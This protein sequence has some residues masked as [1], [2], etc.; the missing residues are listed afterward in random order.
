M[1]TF[2]NNYIAFCSFL[3]GQNPAYT[4]SFQPSS[5]SK[6]ALYANCLLIPVLMW[7]INTFM[8]V[9]HTL[10]GGTFMAIVASIITAFLIFLV[11]RA[12][13]MAPS[14]KFIVW[15]RMSLGFAI[16]LLGSLALDEVIFKKDIDNQMLKYREAIVEDARK[17]VENAYQLRIAELQ[18]EVNKKAK[19]WENTLQAASME[20]DGTGGSGQKQVG[21]ITNLKLSVANRH[22]QDYRMESSKLDSMKSNFETEKRNA[23]LSAQKNFSGE[24]LLLR[25]RALFDLVTDNLIMLLV[26]AI[27]TF[28]LFC[29]EFI[30]VLVKLFSTE[31]IDEKIEKERERLLMLKTQKITSRGEYLYRPEYEH[32]MV[33]QALEMVNRNNSIFD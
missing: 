27:F 11:E 33:K 29:L 9:S 32:P 5:K 14:N 13:I 18:I 19:V 22:E 17:N 20:A 21:A 26:Y 16:A 7:L 10:H 3:I 25:I 8:L 12:I 15:F 30:V 31:S 2:Y 23:M 6:I 28:V 1:T 4:A 24:S